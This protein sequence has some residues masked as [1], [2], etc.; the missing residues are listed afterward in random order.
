MDKAAEQSFDVA[1][2]GAGFVGLALVASLERALP[3]GLRIAL[4]DAADVAGPE[5]GAP[6]PRASAITAASRKLLE[7][8]G[9]WGKV[10]DRAEPFRRIE[11]SDSPLNAA[12]RPLLLNFEMDLPG[13]ETAAH[14]VENRDLLRALR[15]RVLGLKNVTLFA[16]DTVTGFRAD[17]GGA[18][19][20]LKQGGVLRS[21]LVAAADGRRSA[22]RKM[23]GIKIV[24]WQYKQIGIAATVEH[25]APHE[26]RA[27]Q[28]FLP[29]G[30]FA[31]LPLKGNR[32][33][34]VWS[35]EEGR[36]REILAAGSERV[37]SEIRRRFGGRLGEVRLA[38]PYGGFPLDMH[39]ARSFV[40]E[41]IALVGDAAHGLHP[42]A[43]QGLNIGL[44]DVAALAEVVVETARLG[45]DIGGPDVLDRYQR[46]RRFD[47]ALSGTAMDGLNRLFSNDSDLLRVVRTIGLG[48]VER[49]PG[50]KRAFVREAAGFSGETPRMLRGKPI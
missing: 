7:L 36:A 2:V 4:I 8:L 22:L 15:A 9:V 3:Q 38:G 41:R 16:P 32:S 20:T 49:L 40:G 23:A 43:G 37:L 19:L 1:V 17:G 10:A 30:P 48:L 25:D 21:R 13:E 29:A 24:G 26:G 33:S 28:H 31:I 18:E 11:I 6:D 5:T 14:M 45:L 42:L 46:W 50:L 12:I 27:V 35:E 44:R 47:T 39:L 34:L